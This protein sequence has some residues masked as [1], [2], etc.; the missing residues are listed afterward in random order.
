M[1]PTR[2][3]LERITA[4]SG[5]M[6]KVETLVK[7]HLRPT[8]LWQARE[9]V[10]DSAIRRLSLRVDIPTL[11][12]VA[13]A[14]AA[15]RGEPMPGPGEWEPA[16]WLLARAASLGVENEPARNFLQGKDLLGLGAEPG[17]EIGKILNEAFELQ[18]EGTLA[19]REA[20]L[21]WAKERLGQAR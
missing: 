11:I 12:R 1:E 17:P 10:S 3:F 16:R 5:V 7:E 4:Q 2:K 18:I 20:A 13:W 9:E 21:A 8:Q 14:D 15:G 19:D 6:E